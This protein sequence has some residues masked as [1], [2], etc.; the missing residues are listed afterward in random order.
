MLESEDEN[1]HDHDFIQFEGLAPKLLGERGEIFLHFMIQ[2][3][4]SSLLLSHSYLSSMSKA[5]NS[6]KSISF[7]KF[8]S[9]RKRLVPKET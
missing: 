5:C 9:G 6:K 8:D 7:Q 2:R 4:V 3:G 1:D